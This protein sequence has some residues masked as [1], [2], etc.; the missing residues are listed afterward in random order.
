MSL[1]G[2]GE[3]P[4]LN[5]D[6]HTTAESFF[7]PTNSQPHIALTML[8]YLTA[9]DRREGLCSHRPLGVCV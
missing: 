7:N 6:Y 2:M 5:R 3:Q 9:P 8:T 1:G 4:F